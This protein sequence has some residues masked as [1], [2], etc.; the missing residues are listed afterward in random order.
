MGNKGPADY[1]VAMSTAAIRMWGPN[2]V[3]LG[4]DGEPAIQAL[5]DA[6][7]LAR[8]EHETIPHSGPRRDPK[9]KGAIENANKIVEGMFRT[10]RASIESRYSTSSHWTIGSWAGWSGTRAGS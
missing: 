5:V 3:F 8:K 2:R 10:L 4:A 9:S 7:Q 1:A 6:I